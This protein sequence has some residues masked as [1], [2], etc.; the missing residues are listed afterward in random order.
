VRALRRGGEPTTDAQYRSDLIE[1]LSY[2]SGESDLRVIP[3]SAPGE[4]PQPWLLSSSTAGAE[5]AAEFGLPIAFAYHLRPQNTVEALELYRKKFQPS[6]WREQPWTMISVEAV[7]ADTEAE[8]EYL[9][10]PFDLLRAGFLAGVGDTDLFAPEQAKEQVF[11]PEVE[12]K[13]AQMRVFR[14][15][16]T[17]DQV[18]AEL[19]AVAER[20]GADEL[21]LGTAMYDLDARLHSYELIAA[22][23]AD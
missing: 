7:A 20:T 3:G 22:A 17:T 14:A 9:N 6:R 15:Q 5:L 8:A 21:M 23:V 4:L 13:L 10:R 1:V 19:A 12:E 11:A 2:L 16:G 18:V